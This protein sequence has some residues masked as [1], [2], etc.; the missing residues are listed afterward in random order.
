MARPSFF[1]DWRAIYQ[2]LKD[3]QTNWK[4]KA[5]LVAAIVYLLWPID[6]LPDVIPAI[7]W[8]DDLGVASLAIAYLSYASKRGV[9]KK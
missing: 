3:E 8:L 1:P 4:P 2:F 6:L 7:G 5:V 9:Q